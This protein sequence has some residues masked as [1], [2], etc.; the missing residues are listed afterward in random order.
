MIGAT[1]PRRFRAYG[2]VFAAPFR[3]RGY[4]PTDEPAEVTIEWGATPDALDS[5]VAAGL[6]W[7]ANRDE[8]LLE[9]AGTVRYLVRRDRGIVVQLLEPTGPQD[10]SPAAAEDTDVF[11][12]GLPVAAAL[13]FAGTTVLHGAATEIDGGALLFLGD[14][15]A[16]KSSLAA[17]LA[18]GGGRHLCDNLAVLDA[19]TD[20]PLLRCGP[21]TLNL[22]ADS[23]AELG[24]DPAG[25]ERVRA[26]LAKYVVPV[27]RPHHEPS[28]LRAVVSIVEASA[29]E[30]VLQRLDPMASVATIM[31]NL[32][33]AKMARA[34]RPAT[35]ADA[36]RVAASVPAY[37]LYRPAVGWGPARLAAFVRSA[38]A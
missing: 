25:L 32:F 6:W 13:T 21:D 22:W 38:L 29:D 16:G 35:M 31:T 20:A 28:P 5:P 7:Q 37:V 34:V 2:T 27:E 23:T 12:T 9:V 14:N 26:K 24:H 36:G 18:D 17:A 30:P 19:G 4:A 3:L 1:G 10:R 8:V 11:L 15:G 33:R